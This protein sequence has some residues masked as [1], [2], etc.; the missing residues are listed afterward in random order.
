M[1]LDP[2]VEHGLRDRQFEWD[3]PNHVYWRL[4]S[5]SDAGWMP[6]KSR[7]RLTPDL[8]ETSSW[9]LYRVPREESG[10]LKKMLV[11]TF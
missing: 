10:L 5:V 1:Q 9:M 7:N 4:T 11:S 2:V 8:T 6:G 3:R